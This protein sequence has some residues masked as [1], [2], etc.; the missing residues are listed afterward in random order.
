[1]SLPVIEPMTVSRIAA[2]FDDPDYLFE[3]KHDGF[4]ALAYV[5]AG[6]CDLVSRRKNHYKSFDSLKTALAHLKAAD[7]ILDGEIVCLDGDG[8]RQFNQLLYRREEPAFYVFDLLWL[9][10]HDLRQ[11]PLIERKRQLHK[12]I[13][14]SQCDRVIYAQ[15]I[16]RRGTALYQEICDRD[17]EGMVCN[18][19]DSVYSSTGYWL[20]VLNPNYTQHNGRQE[21]FTAFQVRYAKT[22]QRKK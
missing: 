1:V 18:R 15:H 20:K 4:R 19:N 22:E 6:R 12:L 3:L 2:P 10:G 9:N 21:K 8:Y 16:A 11:L 14:K 5:S 13:A 17:L 7:A